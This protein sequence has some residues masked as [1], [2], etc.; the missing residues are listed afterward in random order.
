MVLYICGGGIMPKKNKKKGTRIKKITKKIKKLKFSLSDV[1]VIFII[2]IVLGAVIGG[3]ITYGSTHFDVSNTSTELN[4]F[5]NTYESI[6][7]SYYKKVD[8]KKNN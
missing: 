5:I 6:S 4:E 1:I 2:S 8:K 3:V 7:A